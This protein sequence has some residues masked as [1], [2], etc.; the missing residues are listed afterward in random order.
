MMGVLIKNPEQKDICGTCGTRYAS[1]KT[2]DDDCSICLD[3]RQYVGD[4]GQVWCSYHELAKNRSIRF[5]QLEDNLYV[6]QPVPNFAIGQQAFLVLSE[7]GNMLWDCIPFL[8]EPAVAFIHSLG[9]LQA[10]A[11]SHPHYYSL[12]VEWST[13]FDCPVYLNALDKD[14][15]MRSS[16][17]INFWKGKRKLLWND[18]QLIHT[19][20]HFLGSAVLYLPCHGNKGSLLTADT[21]YVARDRKSVSFMYSYPNLIPLPQ[22]AIEQIYERVKEPNYETMRGAFDGQVIATDAKQALSKSVQ[23]YLSIFKA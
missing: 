23:R 16:K 9:G 17:Q 7:G 18:M 13:V 22:D 4:N 3:D 8:D 12:M 5:T 1:L 2:T 14:W 6:L 19:G 10:I 20:G 21:I 11:I 15:V